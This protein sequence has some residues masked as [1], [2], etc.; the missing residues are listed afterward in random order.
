MSAPKTNAADLLATLVEVFGEHPEDLISRL[1]VAVET[2][3]QL[4]TLFRSIKDAL[5]RTDLPRLRAVQLAGIGADL[6][7]DRANLVGC[8]RDQYRTGLLAHGIDCG[9]ER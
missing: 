1:C 2:L 9:G 7:V 8:A 3:D 4:E 5:E 6:A